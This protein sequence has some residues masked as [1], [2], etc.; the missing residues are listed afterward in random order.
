MTY[1]APGVYYERVDSGTATVS[2]IR[3]D[4]AAFVGIARRGPLDRAVPIG[5]WRQFQ[6]VFGGVTGSGFLAYAVRAFFENGGRRCWIVRVASRDEAGGASAAGATVFARSGR[7]VWRIEAS[8]PG[9]WGNDLSVSIHPA[10]RAQTVSVPDATS[11]DGSTVVTTSGFE[12]AAVVRLRQD[13]VEHWKVVSEVDAA[14]A[15]LVW[16]HP[17]PALRLAGERPLTGFRTDRP[18]TIESLG[19]T[20]LVRERGRLIAQVEDLTLLPAHPR[21]GPAIL[22][23]IISATGRTDERTP[24]SVARPIVIRSIDG[25][26]Q[27]A[28]PPGAIPIEPLLLAARTTLDGIDD[29]WRLRFASVGGVNPGERLEL[30]DPTAPD[31]AIGGVLI[32]SY[33]DAPAGDLVTLGGDGLSGAQIA[34]HG[35]AVAAGRRLFVR[36][37]AVRLSE[38]PLS[39][40]ADGLAL[41]TAD[42]FIGEVTSPWDSDA[43]IAARR[44]GIAALDPIDEVSVAAVPDIHVQPV[45]PA[46][47]APLPPCC[48][49]DPC[50]T[51]LTAPLA[52]RPAA[53]GDLPPIFA[54]ADIA[55]VQA[56]LVSHCERHRD[57]IA[58]IDPPFGAARSPIDGPAR[59]Q[60]W[61]GRFDTKYAAYYHPWLRVVD[62][63]RSGDEPTRPIPP[64]GHVAG[65]YARSDFR[66]G[67]HKAPANESID[68]AEDVTAAIDEPTHGLFNPLGI[69]AI[70]ALGPR[71]LRIMGAR[72][73]SSDPDWRYVNVRRLLMMIEKAVDISTRWVVFEPND[74]ATRTKL[75][76]S[77]VSFLHALW[78]RGALA[79]TT[80]G[81]A[82]YVR[83]DET[84]NPPESRAAGRFIVEIGVAPAIPFE[85]VVLRVGRT[86]NA[87]EI[88]E[89]SHGGGGSWPS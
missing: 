2:P 40:G 26:E 62:P 34:A 21:Y 39:G 83:C 82:F 23:P 61:R 17:D 3:T 77:I 50:L 49:P 28:A 52:P 42:D 33:V 76:L 67:V 54:D 7:P 41:L 74:T 15:R 46:M 71:G 14:N 85:F 22:G 78:Q 73:L 11:A 35:A 29:P 66:V 86:D 38:I 51:D 59:A 57:R 44:R 19:Y 87:F 56:A 89:L 55:R 31:S 5:S 79:G 53:V 70:R 10:S 16:V 64:S 18:I 1:E 20:V 60:A 9:V 4:I 65:Q 81:E 48:E 6:A 47:H 8:S 32:V 63:L 58:L 37:V 27:P 68:W 72:T 24:P 80:P 25:D 12:R 30:I 75:S 84:N 36:A 69:N 88:V 43:V 45:P 13:T